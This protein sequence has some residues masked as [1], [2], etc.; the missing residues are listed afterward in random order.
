M[1]PLIEVDANLCVKGL[2]QGEHW[3]AL[4]LLDVH[5]QLSSISTEDAKVVAH[6][7]ERETAKTAPGAS[8]DT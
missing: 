8:Q 3:L 6:Q 7:R 1:D 5:L 4:P 2:E